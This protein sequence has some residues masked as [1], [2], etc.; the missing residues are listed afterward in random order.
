MG[1]G[2]LGSFGNPSI[3]TSGLDLVAA[4]GQKWTNFYVQSVCSPSRA[5]LLTGRLPTES[6]MGLRPRFSRTTRRK[7]WRQTKS[8]RGSAQYA[9]LRHRHR[10][11]YLGHLPRFL[12]IDQG[13]DYWFGLPFSHDRNMTV[14]RDKG[15][16]DRG[17]LR[18]QAGVF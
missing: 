6:P 7:V 9:R 2:D 14:P 10:N 13:L 12:S 18:S 17:V 1:Y 8:H 11:W 4:E 5:A 16:K 15:F 3:R